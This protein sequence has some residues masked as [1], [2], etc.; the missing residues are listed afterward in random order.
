METRVH[1]YSKKNKFKRN[2][3][4][5][6]KK[7]FKNIVYLIVGMLSAIYFFLKLF[8]NLMAKWFMKLPRLMQ[9]AL[10][11]LL[12]LNVFYDLYG[13]F[14]SE[15][16]GINIALND[17]ITENMPLNFNVAEEKKTECSFDSTS[18]K[19]A[20]KG[21][22]IGLNEEQVLIS[23]AIS[24]WET[25]NYTSDAYLNK[26][27]VGGMMCSSGLI[28]YATLEDGIIAFVSNLKYN[29]FDIGLTSLELIQPKY[30][31]IGAQNDPNN[32]NQYWLDGTT[33]IYN[34]LIGK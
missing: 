17:V 32:L 14:K 19:I 9:V 2:I 23:I 7:I 22:E 20:E 1:R 27:N 16:K 30:C 3:K 31:P 8:N 15:T 6:I 33:N 29:Y 34:N 5:L 18:C 28:S 11:Y 13:I 21:K 4:I 26:N 24:K 10:I 25:G 12:V